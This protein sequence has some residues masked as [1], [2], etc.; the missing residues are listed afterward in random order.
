MR[1]VKRHAEPGDGPERPLLARIR[2]RLRL[3]ADGIRRRRSMARA[4]RQ[5]EACFRGRLLPAA[6]EEAW[7]GLESIAPGGLF[8]MLRRRCFRVQCLREGP[9]EACHPTLLR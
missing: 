4:R 1:R 5:A 7:A 2:R 3:D 8:G 6:I 9:G